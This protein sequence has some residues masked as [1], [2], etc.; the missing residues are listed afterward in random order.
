MD[1][2]PKKDN[3]TTNKAIKNDNG[4]ESKKVNQRDENKIRISEAETRS[5]SRF[6]D[7]QK[8]KKDLLYGECGCSLN[9]FKKKENEEIIKNYKIN[10]NEDTK[11]N[12]YDDNVILSN[13]NENN[14]DILLYDYY[15]MDLEKSSNEND[16]TYNG[17]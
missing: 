4:V 12:N 3:C 16:F 2:S 7:S 13:D 8:S 5:N 9:E 11:H 6:D 1:S 15:I 17:K 10:N 14:T